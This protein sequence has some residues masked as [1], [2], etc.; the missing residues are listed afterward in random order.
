MGV[1]PD[2]RLAD[3]P[4]H[5][6]ACAS[7]A[8]RV[9]VRKASWQQ[10]SVQWS[11]DAMAACSSWS[12]GSAVKGLPPVCDRLRDSIAQAVVD[13]TLPVLAPEDD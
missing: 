7:C 12:P 5:P 13:G 1:R 2:N 6:V 9:L 10:T 11:D 3:A 4:M 8:A